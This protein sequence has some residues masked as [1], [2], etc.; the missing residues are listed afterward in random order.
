[1]PGNKP[2]RKADRAGWSWTSQ[3]DLSVAVAIGLAVGLH[4]QPTISL[5]GAEI[6]LSLTDL[7]APLL[8]PLMIWI[9]FRNR[10]VL[11]PAMPYALAGA[12]AGTL[13]MTYG[14]ALGASRLGGVEAWA[15]VKYAGWFALLYYFASGSL[16]ALQDPARVMRAFTLPFAGIHAAL[17]T[18]FVLL[19][20]AGA[21]W[22]GS[23]T[24]RMYG[25]MDNPNAYGLSLLCGV[26]LVLALKDRLPGPQ[27]TWEIVAGLLAAGVLLTNSLGALGGLI[28]IF[29]VFLIARREVLSL[30]R[31]VLVL[32]AVSNL[33]A[34]TNPVLNFFELGQPRK[35]ADRGITGKVLN[36]DDYAFSLSARLA[37]NSRALE[38][39][40][41][42]PLFGAGLGTFMAS[43]EARA[44][45][46]EE[47]F[48]VHN[49]A[50]WLL[51]EFGLV[52]VA[53][54]LAAIVAMFV[55]LIRNWRDLHDRDPP[56]AAI[57]LSGLM[58][59]AGWVTMSL[60]HEVMYQ[61]LPWLILGMC[62]CT[63]LVAHQRGR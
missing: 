15:L 60:A 33:P 42:A 11:E 5:A 52:G 1:M 62:L 56:E 3:A 16:L 14:F 8:L 39:W 34:V 59:L 21:Q 20:C 25:L 22:P 61:R 7:M 28:A 32:L 4:L 63:V 17:V 27:Y 43:E 19:A 41:N 18:V 49:T 30:V 44:S 51:T 47:V 35:H 6:R 10:P 57:A 13:V 24:P 29:A 9:W 23:D 45:T 53:I 54:F 36:P 31:I 26:S 58:V 12:A 38:F 37:S 55:L 48:Q 46:G 2:T 40:Q 50:L